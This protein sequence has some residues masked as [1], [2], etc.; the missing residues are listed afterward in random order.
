MRRRTFLVAFTASALADTRQDL[1]DLF[2]RMAAAL[3]EGDPETFLRAMDPSMPDY[4][5]FAVNLRA[6]ALQNDLSSSIEINRQEGGD[7]IQL[8]ETRLA[9]RN[10]RQ[11]SDSP[12]SSAPI[13]GEMPLGAAEQEVAS[14]LSRSG[15]LLCSAVGLRRSVRPPNPFL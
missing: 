2:G 11:G 9:A 4:S 12:F 15:R 6:L 5:R 7:S 14:C 1:V 13:H 3:S 8:V 10:P